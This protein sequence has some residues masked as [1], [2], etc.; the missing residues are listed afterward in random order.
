LIS[1]LPFGISKGRVLVI[2]PNLT[3]KDEL[4]KTLNITNKREC[5]WLKCNI[6]SKDIMITGPYLAIL[7]S[8]DSNIHDC[9]QSHFVLTNIQQLAS[10]A[11]KWLPQFDDDYFDMI[12]VDEGHHN[13]APS[14]KKVF[15]KFPNAKVV[16]LTATPFRSD[17]KLL[18]GQLI[19]KYPFKSSMIKGYIKKLQAIYVTPEEL[20]FTYKGKEKHYTLEDVLS[21]KE[22]DWFSRGVALAQVCNEHIVDASLEKLELLRQSGTSHQLIAVACSVEHARQIRSLYSERGYKASEIHSDMSITDQEK[23]IRDLRAGL[24]DCIVQV[25]MLGEGFDHPKLSVAA[26]FR[27]FRSLSPYVQFVG[28]IMRVIVQS[29]P[30]HPDNL[31]YIVTHIGLNLDKQL[32]DFKS[33]DKE[34]QNFFEDLLDGKESELPET[35]R[36]GSARKRLSEDMIVN[37]EIIENFLEE[38]FISQDDLELQNALK[39]AA[40]SLG[41]DSE[42][43]EEFLNKKRASRFRTVKATEKFPINPQQQRK[44][45]RIRLNERTNHVAKIL[46]NRIGLSSGGNELTFKYLKGEVQGTNFVAAVQLIHHEI[47]RMLGINSNERACLRTEEFKK[48]IDL[49]EEI[50]NGLTRRL[51]KI[52]EVTDGK[53][54]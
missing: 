13:V 11:D 53:E 34:D 48:A 37:N 26:I 54:R 27:P 14:W 7:D 24:L 29:F 21:L 23:V 9:D 1:I 47:N 12:L 19:Y 44:E 4:A 33:L 35:V 16:S 28:R 52:M 25:Q 2:A 5:F 51:I 30:G 45:A 39:A 22:E 42:E 8:I 43:L 38:D 40:E 10:S 46:I 32:D 49:L 36:D 41:Y 20:Y 18:E 3:I 17:D 6:L 31:G 50:V 15:K